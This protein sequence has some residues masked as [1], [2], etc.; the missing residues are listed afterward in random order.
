MLLLIGLIL[1]LVANT[2]FASRL[3]RA[4]RKTPHLATQ[5]GFISKTGD[6][7]P[8]A[9]SDRP[10]V[11]VTISVIVPAYNEADNIEDCL[12][13]ILNSSP[14][15]ADMLEVWMVDDQ[16]TDQTWTIAQNLQQRLNDPRLKLLAGQP[17]PTD[18]SWTGKNWACAQAAERANGEFLLFVD[19]DVR[20]KPGAIETSVQAAQQDQTDLLSCGPAIICGCLAEW[21]VQPLMFNNIMVG[22]NA[23]AVNDPT[24][25]TAF[26]AG[27]FMLF[28]R[29]AYEKVGGHRAVASDV[30]EDVELARRIKYSG[31]TLRFVSGSNLVA[32]RMYQS[33][34]ALWEGWT[35]NLYLGF[36]R[37]LGTAIYFTGLMLLL[38]VLPWLA[39][40]EVLGNAIFLPLTVLDWAT[41]AL[42]LSSIAVHYDMR[43]VGEQES[44]IA[45]RYWWLSGIGGLL[46]AAITIASVIKTETGWGWTWRDRPLKQVNG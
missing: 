21:L 5:D 35:K 40:I 31:L 25:E 29:T 11:V 36:Q 38:Y 39:L 43:R 44:Q 23:E 33:W 27:P 41:I 42:A 37:N 32:V 46:L 2:V 15:S 13:A 30:V 26:A 14:L 18:V 34:A 7:S 17:R 16:S 45:P 20:L 22:F 10:T 3:R 9:V 12:T 6:G 19:A 28:R 24:S 8:Q 1:A 4:I